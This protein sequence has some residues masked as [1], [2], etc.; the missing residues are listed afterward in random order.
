LGDRVTPSGPSDLAHAQRLQKALA[1]GA[2]STFLHPEN[3]SAS[4]DACS[5]NACPIPPA[6]ESEASA[7]RLQFLEQMFQASP[8]GLTI[9]D[10]AHRILMA[11]ETFVHMFGYTQAEVVG[12]P[13]ENLVVPPDRLAESHWVS[14]AL[15]KGEQITLET[16][17]RKK[18]G[19]LLDVSVSCAPLLLNGKMSGFYAGY[20]DISDR[21]RVEALSSALYR[22]AEK[23]S[24]A[25]DLQQFFAAV[26]GIVDE[27]MYARNFYI[28]LYD[29]ATEL[30]S[31]P[32]FV[33]EHDSAPVPK[34]LGHGLTEYLLRS[35]EPLLATPEILNEMEERGDVS[36]SRK[37]TRSLDW[38]GV[39]LKVG[40]HTFGAL[41][42]QTYSKNIRYGVRDKEILTFV[43][44]QLA[45]AVEIKR[46]EQALRRSEARYRS[47]VQSSV[48]GIYR[49]SLEGRF[50]DVNPALITMLGYSSVEEVL[51]L[52]PE[53]D[54]FSNPEEHQR[55]IDEFRRSGRMDGFEVKWKRKD[56][57]SITVRISGRAVSSADEP[58]DVLEAIAEDITERRVL[59]D[60]FRQAQKMEAVGRLAGGVAHDFNNLLMVISGYTEVILSKIDSTHPLHEKGRSI[61]QAA[62]RATTLTRQ[63]LAFSRK[64]LLELKVVDLNAIVQDMERLLR[65]LI[66]EN[67]E[68]VATLAPDAGH[69]RADAGQLE[70]VL[71]NLVVNAKDAMPNGG[72]LSIR[73]QRTVVDDSNRW[74]QT[75]IRP[76]N[77]V[78]LS[79]SDTGMGMDKDTQSRIFEPFFTTKEKGKGTGLGLSTVYGIVKQSGGYVMVQSDKGVGTIFNI[80]LPRVDAAVDLDTAP[81]TRV[82]EGG[83]ETV[84]LVEDEESVRQLVRET[85]ETRGY[86]VLE[87]E[88]GNAGLE[89]AAG[90]SGKIDLVITDVVMPGISGRELA[91]EL[92]KLRPGI[93]VL[94]LSGYTEDTFMSEGP[95]ERGTAF[96]QKP[97]TLQNLSRKVREV[98]S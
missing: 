16:Q 66:G 47:L 25:H 51:L 60:Q 87:A 72:K 1:R 62:D 49:A 86:H 65:P 79:V 35:G 55:L 96:L 15:T 12:Q 88:N 74:G 92:L 61:Q 36:P 23:S 95:M 57:S 8:D 78:V 28:A 10:S 89:V 13:L 58:A 45:S 85:L 50:L 90:F 30:L 4:H 39:P 42:V 70:Q 31:F 20:H 27:L 17:R 53:K 21:K 40:N 22:V 82:A 91:Q 84:L 14:E 3:G 56:G 11:N 33:D 2:R 7:A 19:S 98:L 52:D 73:T 63:L 43:A 71:M 76:G 18:D 64:Q 29:P 9:A 68:L 26:H 32:Y 67:I 77:Y 75:F 37:G 44:R 93:K 94:Y 81:V 46:N 54:V 69:T 34:K 41:V 97:F 48:Y 38:M 6:T 24:S 5:E 83:S 80:Y 59:E